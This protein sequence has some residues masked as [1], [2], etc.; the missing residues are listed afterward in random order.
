MEAI[1][2]IFDKYPN[3][4]RKIEEPNDPTVF[5]TTQEAVFVQLIH[6]FM[7]PTVQ[8]FSIN[9]VYEHLEGEDLLFCMEAMITFFQKD[10]IKVQDVSQTFFD[11]RLLKKQIVGQKKFS[12][13]VEEAI[14]GIKFRPSM[15]YMYWKRRSDRIPRPDLIID[16]TPYW[17]TSSVESFIEKEKTRQKQK[18]KKV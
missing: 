10:T 13:M 4:K 5:L 15:V 2:R 17:F 7:N 12:E 6:F 9:M 18:K 11:T 14:E 8:Q 3:V 16:G 1:K